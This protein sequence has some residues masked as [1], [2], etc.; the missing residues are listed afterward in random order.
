MQK[1]R[2]KGGIANSKKLVL[3]PCINTTGG[4][5]VGRKK[6][7]PT[8]FHICKTAADLLSKEKEKGV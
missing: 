6:A 1:Q 7:T 4:K 2:R 3:L 5:T 8:S